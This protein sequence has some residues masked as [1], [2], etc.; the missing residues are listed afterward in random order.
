MPAVPGYEG[1]WSSPADAP[2]IDPRYKPLWAA[3]ND[4][5]LVMV[6]HADAAAAT[7]GLQ[8]YTHGGLNMII[9]KTLPGEMIA[10]LIVGHV[11]R[12][13]PNLRLV[14]VETGVGWMA[15]FIKWM[16]VLQ[17]EHPAMYP[18][19]T[20]RLSETFHRHVFGSFLWDT[21]GVL[22]RDVIGVN[23]IMWCNDF[24]HAYG[25]WPNSSDLIRKELAD[26]DEESRHKVLAGNAVRVFRL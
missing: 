24:P 12:D 1:A 23:N 17:R 14:C 9:N 4:L 8:D 2:Y 26:I 11:F 5:D 13:Y 21:V 20:E 10:S 3:L 22:N 6:V 25:P 16:D 18:G 19:H 7:E 15:H